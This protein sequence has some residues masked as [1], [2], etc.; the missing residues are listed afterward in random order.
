[1]KF[2]MFL[3][4]MGLFTYANADELTDSQKID[5][6]LWFNKQSV[7]VMSYQQDEGRFVSPDG[8]LGLLKANSNVM[9]I[10]HS[11]VK[12]SRFRPLDK[13]PF[14]SEK[15]KS[16]DESDIIYIGAGLKYSSD[17]AIPMILYISPKRDVVYYMTIG[18]SQVFKVDGPFESLSDVGEKI[19]KQCSDKNRQ[20]VKSKLTKFD[21]IH[22]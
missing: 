12:V 21:K 15:P 18:S 14:S 17:P 8:I 6:A 1:M 11:G 2:K 22:K 20:L 9:V 7:V 5:A 16:E 10:K 13:V 3:F 4:L 19:S